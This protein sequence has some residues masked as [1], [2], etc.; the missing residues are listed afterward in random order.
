MHWT[1]TDPRIDKNR[2]TD[3]NVK[4]GGNMLN[5]VRMVKYWQRRKTMPTMNSYL[6]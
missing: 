6:L 1:K 3:I 4:L 2:V 5:V